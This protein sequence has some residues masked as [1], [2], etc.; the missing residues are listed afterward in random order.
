MEA[1]ASEAT[2][3]ISWSIDEMKFLLV[4]INS[5][6]IHSNLAVYCLKA[7]AGEY[8]DN[9][10]IIEYTI[11]NRTDDI[12][13][14]IYEECPDV[15]GFSC[16]IWN[17]S[18]VKELIGE[19]SKILPNVPIWLGGPEVSYNPER[20]VGVYPNIAGVM[21]GEGER[22]FN[23][24][25]SCYSLNNTD[26]IPYIKGITTIS[27]GEL[28][29]NPCDEPI[30]MNTIHID[31]NTETLNNRI[32]YYESQRGCPFSCSYC[33]SSV[34]KHLRFK[35][36]ELVKKELSVFL[37]NKVPQVKFVDRTFNC[38]RE[39]SL[40]IWRFIKEHDNGI[41]NFHFEIAADLLNE[42]T[43]Q[44][45]QSMRRGLVQL[46][47][48]V[49]STNTETIKAIH[50]NMNL[51][52]LRANVEAIM[53]YQNIHIHLDL[54]AGL[55]YEDFESFQKSFNDIYGMKPHDLQLGF[56]KLLHGSGIEKETIQYG[57][58]GRNMPP[59]EVLYTKWISYDELLKL[60]IIEN[61]VEMYYNSGMFAAGIRYAERFFSDAFTM[62]LE[63]GEFYDRK[64]PSGSLPSRNGKY[65][66]FYEFMED[67]LS[68]KDIMVLAE[69][70]KFDMLCKDNL[71]SFPNFLVPD[72]DM[73]ARARM[74]IPDRK[75]TKAEHMEIFKIDVLE[76]LHSDIITEGEFPIYFN[77]L[78]RDNLTNNATIKVWTN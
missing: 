16:Y 45:L 56:L 57:I 40:E 38:N 49:Q 31:Y 6:Y 72:Y 63:F 25:I 14:G 75:L 78:E 33:L 41:T 64:Y 34:D 10:S 46:E 20:Y 71:K 11:N 55:P 53:K 22:T 43:I 26:E 62:Y 12:L 15:I 52:V 60:K 44:L 23:R 65:E 67:K 9:V 68:S 77:Y 32:I 59:Y 1:T 61:V 47:I 4:A 70:L 5:K 7:A 73:A 74:L 30:D 42:E 18:I 51:D 48:G 50:R 2:R 3:N 39:H 36:T 24:L 54:I 58:V 8:G 69:L 29:D 27:D 37:D 35:D 76:F 21:K 28:L 17:I 66:L 13:R 19:L